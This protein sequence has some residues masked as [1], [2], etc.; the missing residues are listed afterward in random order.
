MGQPGIDL[1]LRELNGVCLEQENALHVYGPVTSAV[2]AEHL[3][4]SKYF[5]I[6]CVPW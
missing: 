1:S 5:Q 4:S 6:Q 2:G 3:Q